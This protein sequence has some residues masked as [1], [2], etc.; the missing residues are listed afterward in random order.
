MPLTLGCIFKDPSHLSF[1]KEMRYCLNSKV[2]DPHPETGCFLIHRAAE[3]GQIEIIAILLQTGDIDINFPAP[4]QDEFYGEAPL[5]IALSMRNDDMASFLITQKADV[6]QCSPEGEFPLIKAARINDCKII[7]ELIAA[8]ADVNQE[9]LISTHAYSV[10]LPFKYTNAL[11]HALWGYQ[12]DAA[13]LLLDCGSAIVNS[14]GQ[15]VLDYC[16]NDTLRNKM[17]KE[18]QKRCLGIQ[19]RYRTLTENASLPTEV[20]KIVCSY[21]PTYPCA[22]NFFKYQR[23]MTRHFNALSIAPSEQHELHK[24][25]KINPR[26]A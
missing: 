12:V 15:S 11:M 9:N 6:G 8:G 16:Y 20:A 10:H 24:R 4:Q 1:L 5:N 13:R 22:S 14:Q 26:P 3:Y 21:L 23:K 25:R 2:S 18:I 17:K 19:N 7:R